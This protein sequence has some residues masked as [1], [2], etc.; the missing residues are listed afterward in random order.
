MNDCPIL[1]IDINCWNCS[2]RTF[3]ERIKILKT[4]DEKQ[5]KKSE[6]KLIVEESTKNE[7]KQKK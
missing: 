5:I 6:N 3:S 4:D 2:N 1:K 7:Y